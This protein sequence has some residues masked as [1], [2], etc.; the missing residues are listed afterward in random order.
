M[1]IFK[2]SKKIEEGVASAT[3][4]TM[5]PKAKA[6]NATT[7]ESGKKT[8]SVSHSAMRTIIAPLA[9]EKTARL[10]D[11]GVYAFRV[12][13]D[14]NRVSVKQAVRELYHVTPVRVNIINVGGTS[15]RFGRHIGRTSDWKKALVTLPKGS[16]IN[17]FESV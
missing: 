5:Q 13:K 8:R 9:T 6:K 17:V 10:A 3:E 2:R 4:E 7:D 12:A 14:A 11:H 16:H 1:A 15:K